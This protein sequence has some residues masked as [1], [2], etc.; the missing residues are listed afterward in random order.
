[1]PEKTCFNINFDS[2][3]WAMSSDPKASL[4][5]TFFK[6][7]DR[8]FELSDKYNFKYTIFVI[9]RDLENPEVAERVRSWAAKGHEIGNHS[10]SHKQ[11]LGYLGCDE[12]ESEVMRSHEIITKVCGREPKGFIAP[13]WATSAALI[14]ILIKNGYLYDTSVF[15]SYFMWPALAKLWWN[16]RND[17]RRASVWQRRDRIANL[18]GHRMPYFSKGE[19]LMKKDIDGLLIFPLPSTPIFRIPCWHTV[20]FLFPRP[21]FAAVLNSC[22][23]QKYF[24]YLAHPADLLDRN[25]IRAEN[26]DM[27][28][29]ERLDVSLG[30]KKEIFESAIE[31]IVKRSSCITTLEEIA[32]DIISENRLKSK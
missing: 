18:F 6:V 8:F 26:R 15:P 12:L 11:N 28:N 2:L 30:R 9:G 22:L 14:D 23:N 31:L 27:E 10:Y 17:E 5:P 19:S 16:F 1:M 21:L 24:Y 4:D 13:A 20:S 3:G 7:A 32:K 25:D 29:L